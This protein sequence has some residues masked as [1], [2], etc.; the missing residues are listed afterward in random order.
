MIRRIATIAFLAP[1]LAVRAWGQTPPTGG[2]DPFARYLFPPDRILAHAQEIGLEE[3]QKTA[4]RG[5]VLKAQPRFTEAQLDLQGEVEKM[6][7]LLQERPVDE[8]KV[9]A[10]VDRILVLEKDIKKTQ[11]SLLV[12][13]K[14]A[15]S[16]GQQAKLAQLLK[17]S[18][19][20]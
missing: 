18:P 4:I 15:L 19:G 9:L 10:Q 20:P 12:R 5:E 11:I 1:V 7:R 8:T 6:T 16:P 14:N 17:T 3:A 2:E 13:I